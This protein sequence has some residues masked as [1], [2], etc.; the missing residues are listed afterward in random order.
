MGIGVD[1]ADM[2]HQRV[3]RRAV[4]FALLLLT[5]FLLM[6]STGFAGVPA[7]RRIA[8]DTVTFA[9]DGSRYAAWEVRGRAGIV[10]LDTR[11]GRTFTVQ[12]SCSLESGAPAA[13]GRFLVS[14]N[15]SEQELLDARTG[16]LLP[17][18]KPPAHEYGFYGPLWRGVGLRYVVGSAGSNGECLKAKRHE[19]CTALYDIAT[20]TV[21]ELAESQVPDPDLPGAPPLCQALR[22]KAYVRT[23]FEG[24]AGSGP[25][26]PLGRG[27][28][29]RSG[30]FAHLEQ[31]GEAPVRHIRIERC[32]GPAT[33]VR[34]PREPRERNFEAHNFNVEIGGGF[35]TWDTGNDSS[36]FEQEEEYAPRADGGLSRGTLFAYNLRTRRLHRWKLP[37]LRLQTKGRGREPV[38]VGVFG[39]SAHTG[40][41]AFWIAARSIDC[42]NK[43]V[44][45]G[46]TES[47][48]IYAA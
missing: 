41:V 20:G 17:L 37:K 1:S 9:S 42:E 18:P 39:Y 7:L 22:Q 36:D 12:S 21:S 16:A 38:P 33:V 48:D 25:L 27:F 2:Q 29:F 30:L 32:H 13:V 11:S 6:G 31:I 14:C 5:A 15:G 43:K 3:G 10:I 4:L 26:S 8:T 35:L 34:M 19:S 23:K 45:C 46:D 47:S 24:L 44:L 40:Y 28:S